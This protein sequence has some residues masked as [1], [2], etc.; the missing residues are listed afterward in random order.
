MSAHP[1]AEP[2]PRVLVL[3]S[4]HAAGLDLLRS[5]ADVDLLD[6]APL[7]EDELCARVATCQ[8]VIT[9]GRTPITAAV[10]AAAPNLRIVARRRQQRQCRR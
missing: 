7:R 3:D 1:L 5:V 10:L 6:A 8:A 4:I 9:R 2:R